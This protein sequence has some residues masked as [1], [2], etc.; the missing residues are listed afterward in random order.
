MRFSGEDGEAVLEIQSLSGMQP[1]KPVG[2]AEGDLPSPYECDRPQV[3]VEHQMEEGILSQFT[4]T[5][6][7]VTNREEAGP[8]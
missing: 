5:E 6:W 4:N 7:G 8:P 1:W 3:T 2:M